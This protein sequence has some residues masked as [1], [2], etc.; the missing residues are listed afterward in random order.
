MKHFFSDEQIKPL[1]Q[2]IQND[3]S[4]GYSTFANLLVVFLIRFCCFFTHFLILVV[5]DATVKPQDTK[6]LPARWPVSKTRNNTN[7][8]LQENKVGAS[9][10]SKQPARAH[11]SQTLVGHKQPSSLT[12][13]QFGCERERSGAGDQIGPLLQSAGSSVRPRDLL[14]AAAG[15]RSIRS[16]RS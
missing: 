9:L 8:N 15:S 10:T 14:N 3:K 13:P 11:V 16:S 5:C 1:L 7:N 4:Y 6:P 12:R 2:A